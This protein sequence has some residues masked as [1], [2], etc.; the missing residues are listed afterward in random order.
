V[1]VQPQ[2]LGIGYETIEAMLQDVEFSNA[3][4]V[5]LVIKLVMT[6]IKRAVVW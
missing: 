1:A 4:V 5:L 6:A 2:I 3:L